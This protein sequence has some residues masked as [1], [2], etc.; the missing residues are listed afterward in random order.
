MK[1]EPP[2]IRRL[3]SMLEQACGLTCTPTGNMAQGSMCG[4]GDRAQGSTCSTGTRAQEGQCTVG[5]RAQGGLCM[6]GNRASTFQP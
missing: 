1:Y 4:N 5:T 2:S 6:V 3:A